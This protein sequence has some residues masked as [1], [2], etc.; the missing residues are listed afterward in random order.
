MA[1]PRE[2]TRSL[3]ERAEVLDF[4][5]ELVTVTSETL[6]LDELLATVADFVHR[7]VPHDVFAI[8]LYQERTRSLRIRYGRGHRPEVIRNLAVPLGEGITGAAAATR[9]P[10]LVDDVY[11][12]PRY[13]SALDAVRSEL[14]VPMMARGKLVGVIDVS[15]TRP[16][17]FTEDDGALLRLIATRVATSIDNARLYRRVERSNRTLK[18]LAHVS[19]EF[20]SILDLDELLEQVA[21]TVR[22]LISYDAF[23]VL[24]LDAERKVLR[25]QFCLRGEERVLAQE[26][27]LA[28]GLTGAAARERVAVRVGDVTQDRR[29]LPQQPHV[30]SEMA[31]PLIVRDTVVG[32]LDLESTR[33]NFFTEEHQ[34]LM[35][36]LAPQVAVAVENARL[37]EEIARKERRL[38]ADLQAAR[39]LQSLL[40]PREAPQVE[41]LDVAFG[42]RPARGVS[43]D[44]FD[45]FM[46]E[47]HC[48]VAAFGDVSGKGAAAALYASMVSGLLRTLAPQIHHPGLLLQALNEALLE[49]QVD[50]TFVTLTLLLWDQGTGILTMANAGAVPPLVCRDGEQM[51]LT[52]GGI[53]LGLLAGRDYE[54]E[55][56]ETQPGDVLVLYSD[57]VQDQG[58]GS[59][60]DRPY[61]DRRVF[62]VLKR[63]CG[64]SAQGIVDALLADVD[65]YRGNAP[66]TDD[67]TIIVLKVGERPQEA[68][69]GTPSNTA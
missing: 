33:L 48:F 65:R 25:H 39:Q 44:L 36:L 34:R 12:D 15:S 35:S 62:S 54:E 56:L 58:D 45:F 66:I 28:S 19:R 55:R 14:A 67:Q 21:R 69:C 29:Y 20:A 63:A 30:L 40:L 43:G 26:V 13:L 42:I 10:V 23:S 50:A 27:P 8:L 52:S 47:G 3:R 16:G 31:L 37:Y 68:A 51:R 9:Q 59:E 49:R 41:G 22:T 32:V 60:P 17:A 24:L 57:G 4:L 5:L 46:Y 11:A 18:A 53:P 64:L 1:A 38:E 6:D 7:V 2:S 61:G